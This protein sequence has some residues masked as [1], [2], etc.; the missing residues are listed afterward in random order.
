MIDEKR[1]DLMAIYQAMARKCHESDNVAMQQH[2]S[3]DWWKL[4]TEDEAAEAP[5]YLIWPGR[6]EN[7]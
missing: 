6:G 1:K 4:A 2:W 3:Q 5:E 7:G